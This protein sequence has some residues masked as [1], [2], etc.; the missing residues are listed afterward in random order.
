METLGAGWVAEEA[1]AIAVYSTRVAADFADGVL[2]AVNHSGD[3]DSTGSMTGNLLGV[4]YGLQVIPSRW[5]E[6]LEL[7]EEIERIAVDLDDITAGRRTLPQVAKDY[8]PN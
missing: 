5:L 2:L 7:R 4:L 8:P 3:S 6:A 1:L